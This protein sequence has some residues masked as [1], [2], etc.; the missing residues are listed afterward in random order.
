MLERRNGLIEGAY[1]IV[2]GELP[3]DWSLHSPE[4]LRERGREALRRVDPEMQ[5]LSKDWAL[6][7]A[8]QRRGLVRYLATVLKPAVR[9]LLSEL[10]DPVLNVWRSPYPALARRLKAYDVELA[11]QMEALIPLLP[12]DA[13]TEEDVARRFFALL[14]A[15]HRRAVSLA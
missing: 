12:P 5:R 11:A 15:V 8:M 1:V 10:G 13:H 7:N 3:E 2:H 4:L 6:A 14:Q 9:G